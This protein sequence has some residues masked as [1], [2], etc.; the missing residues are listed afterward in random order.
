MGILNFNQMYP[1]FQINLILAN[2]SIKQRLVE[3]QIT[4]GSLY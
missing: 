3:T 1:K 4:F 2:I